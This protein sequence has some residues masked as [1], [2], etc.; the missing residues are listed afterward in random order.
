MKLAK[1]KHSG[2]YVL[3]NKIRDLRNDDFS[4]KNNQED[5]PFCKE[6]QEHETCC[7]Y[8]ELNDGEWLVRSIDNKYPALICD[9]EKFEK[10]E[11]DYG[12]HEVMIETQD[13]YKS[14]YN[15]SLEEFKCIIRMYKERYTA[16]FEE[17]KIKS[18]VLYK[19]HLKNAGASKVHS[20][21]QI[22][23]MSFLPPAI[24]MELEMLKKGMF[25][26]EENAIFENNSYNVFMPDDSYLSGEIIIKN[27]LKSNFELI[28]MDEINDLCEIFKNV[29]GKL[30]IIYGEIPFNIF[31]H[32]Q[33]KDIDEK[34]FR[35]HIHII[36][37]KGQF[38]GFELGTGLFINSLDTV[39][40]AK[41]FK[42]L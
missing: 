24:V 39:N 30:A 12:K 25:A 33:P 42:E 41:K 2:R 35:W 1:N 9:E 13:H 36:P 28:Q 17:E 29:F 32:S 27:K 14:F 4:K 15:F 21:S 18:V 16:L 37:R 10:K 26:N 6:M 19:N 7:R 11:I 5:C 38:G 34:E 23:S 8:E 3:I 22:L 20:H 40:L 31:L